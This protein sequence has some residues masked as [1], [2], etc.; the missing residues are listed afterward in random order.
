M[1]KNT[2]QHI[3]VYWSV[4]NYLTFNGE[5]KSPGEKINLSNTQNNEKDIYVFLC[6][7]VS[8]LSILE[9][10][11]LFSLQ[12]LSYVQCVHVVHSECYLCQGEKVH[13]GAFAFCR[14]IQL[15][16]VRFVNIH[17]VKNV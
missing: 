3:A 10:F 5:N 2:Q 15:H 7:C 4:I 17:N 11:N 9:R 1:K 13:S 16:S 6:V 14:V 12:F 8:V